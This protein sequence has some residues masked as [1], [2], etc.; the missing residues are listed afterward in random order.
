M[1]QAFVD[2]YVKHMSIS[3][4]TEEFDDRGALYNLRFDIHASSLY[5]GNLTFRE[6]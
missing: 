4:P 3:E 1:S 5:P 6:R 2:E